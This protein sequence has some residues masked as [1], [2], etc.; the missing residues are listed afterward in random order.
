MGTYQLQEIAWDLDL[1]RVEVEWN[2]PCHRTSCFFFFQNL[3]PSVFKGMKQFCKL[4][5]VTQNSISLDARLIHWNS[6]HELWSNAA[7]SLHFTSCALSRGGVG[8][9]DPS[10]PKVSV[11]C[12]FWLHPQFSYVPVHKI[13]PSPFGSASWSP[14]GDLKCC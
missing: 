5:S 7:K 13:A 2:L 9:P 14:S 6:P 12:I 10:S 11:V 3:S 1:S 4:I 8:G